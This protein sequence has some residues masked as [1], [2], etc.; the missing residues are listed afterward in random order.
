MTDAV[1]AWFL[2]A[3]E[4]HEAPWEGIRDL[5]N[6]LDELTA[7]RSGMRSFREWVDT[8][9]RQGRMRNDDVTLFRIEIV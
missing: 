2:R 1:A 8:A 6:K 9:R 5:D 3:V 4:Q 7:A